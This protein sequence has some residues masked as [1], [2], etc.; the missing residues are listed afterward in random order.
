MMTDDGTTRAD[1]RH[2]YQIWVETIKNRDPA[3]WDV[4]I[5]SFAEQLRA[6]IRISLLKQRLPAEL[7]EDVSQ[8]T[9]LT[10][11]RNIHTFVWEDE[12]RFYRWLRVIACNHIFRAR[13]HTE[14]E[15]SVDDFDEGENELRPFFE[16]YHLQGRSVEDEV[17]AGEQMLALIQ[18]MKMLKP[19]EREILVRWL[20]GE[21][22]R[23]LAA[24][25]QKQP[26]TISVTIW[27]AKQ[28]VEAS[29]AAIQAGRSRKGA[30]LDDTQ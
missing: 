24:D 19:D 30:S 14:R 26:R 10:A 1:T 3:S 8:E 22:P 25:F 18:A 17:E 6:D 29:L 28:K 20:M 2:P 21:S 23:V 12:E 11:F 5:D 7:L 4:L 13:R 9:W 27:R 16:I 15:Q